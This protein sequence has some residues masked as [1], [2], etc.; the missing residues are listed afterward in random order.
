MIICSLLLPHR[1]QE[2]STPLM[3]GPHPLRCRCA[4]LALF[5]FRIRAKAE[6]QRRLIEPLDKQLQEQLA[7]QSG[8][9]KL[10][11]EEAVALRAELATITEETQVK[12]PTD[13]WHGRGV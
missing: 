5:A 9:V 1:D 8:A 12:P 11:S 6:E 10:L 4:I 13:Y 7:S 3:Y 2:Q